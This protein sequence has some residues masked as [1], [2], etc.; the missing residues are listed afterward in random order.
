MAELGAHPTSGVPIQVKS[1]RFGPY[2]T[3][4]TVNASVPKKE[5]PASVTLERALELLTA[6]EEKL[7]AQG[8]DPHAKKKPRSRKG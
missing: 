4:G 8:K 6:R 3:D 1:G 7:R 5:D 2:V